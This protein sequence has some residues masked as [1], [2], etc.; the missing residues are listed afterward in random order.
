MRPYLRAVCLRE[1]STKRHKQFRLRQNIKRKRK[2]KHCHQLS[3]RTQ[4][5]KW[6]RLSESAASL[7]PRLK[8]HGMY[9]AFY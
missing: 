5:R 9:L 1:A 7:R 2:K 6:L 3:K 4:G 8:L